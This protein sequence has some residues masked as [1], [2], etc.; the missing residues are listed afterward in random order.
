M[1]CDVM[2]LSNKGFIWYFTT[3]IWEVILTLL[4][5]QLCGK[6]WYQQMYNIVVPCILKHWWLSNKVDQQQACAPANKLL[7]VKQLPLIH[8]RPSTYSAVSKVCLS[9]AEMF[10]T[11]VGQWVTKGNWFLLGFAKCYCK[12]PIPERLSASLNCNEN[13]SIL[14][15][16]NLALLK[17]TA[18]WCST[19]LMW[20]SDFCIRLELNCI[21]TACFKVA[22]LCLIL[23]PGVP[24]SQKSPKQHYIENSKMSIDFSNE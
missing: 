16:S 12:W 19:L 3:I 18:F 1:W 17:L 13:V 11:I 22:T 20:F 24:M 6:P 7:V 4:Y 9:G 5:I 10:T 8:D 2:L 21:C 23:P 15:R 14:F